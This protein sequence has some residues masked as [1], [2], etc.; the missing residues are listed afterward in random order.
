V[1]RRRCSLA[2]AAQNKSAIADAMLRLICHAPTDVD[3]DDD[4]EV[5]VCQSA[6]EVLRVLASDD[7]TRIVIIDG[8]GVTT[9]GS[10]MWERADFASLQA[11]GC[12]ALEAIAPALCDASVVMRPSV[13]FKMVRVILAAMRNQRS[14][15]PVQRSGC[16]ALQTILQRAS[17]RAVA[18]AASVGRKRCGALRDSCF[19]APTTLPVTVN[20]VFAMRHAS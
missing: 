4:A 16:D 5:R 17:T 1:S 19:D 7:A 14:S 6:C 9:L 12:D 8:D 13:G 20:F 18:A 3:D 11:A 2:A 10:A 15:E